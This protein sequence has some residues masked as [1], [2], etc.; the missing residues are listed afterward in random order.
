[1]RQKPLIL[2]DMPKHSTSR[3][4]CPQCGWAMRL[5]RI[6]TDADGHDIRGVHLHCL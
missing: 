4:P 3:P 2:G 5:D 1:M 6:Q